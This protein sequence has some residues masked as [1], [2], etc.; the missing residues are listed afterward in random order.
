M[1]TYTVA[2]FCFRLNG[3]HIGG[4][5]LGSLREQT[6]DRFIHLRCISLPPGQTNYTKERTITTSSKT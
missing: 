3:K 5:A 1:Y 6:Y 2:I 4:Q